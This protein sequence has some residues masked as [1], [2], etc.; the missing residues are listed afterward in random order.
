[1]NREFPAKLPEPKLPTRR[2]HVVECLE[3]ID[4]DTLE[5][6]SNIR[7]YAGAGVHPKTGRILE[8]FLRAK[9]AEGSEINRLLDDAGE[10]VSRALQAGM[11]LE[12]LAQGF[13]RHGERRSPDAPAPR[14]S[15]LGVTIDVLLQEQRALDAELLPVARLK[16][17]K[18]LMERGHG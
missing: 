2:R 13:G 3:V 11:S 12:D 4:P 7:A 10:L 1:M 16:L 15:I 17:V 5:P 18:M 8:V 6:I 9:G 14:S